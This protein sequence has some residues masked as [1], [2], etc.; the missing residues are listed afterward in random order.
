MFYEF[1]HPMTADYFK[2]ESG[3]DFSY[4]AHLHHCFEIIA[5]TEGEMNVK[6]DSTEYILHKGEALFVFPNQIHSLHTQLHSSHVLCLFSS[7]LVS[8]YS[9]LVTAK[10]PENNLFMPDYFYI[11]QLK[12]ITKESDII[13]IKG[14]LYSLSGV[15]HK[16]ASY[17][18]ADASSNELLYGIFKFIEEHFSGDCSLLELSKHTG[19][20]YTYLSRYFKKILGISYNDYVNQFRISHACYLLTNNDMTILEISDN[21]GFN[22]VRSLNRN[23]KEQLGITPAEYRSKNQLFREEIDKRK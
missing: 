5:I 21:C 14:L 19:Y 20:E 11:D 13:E 15:F 23:F 8:V 18:D 2:G 4:P 17:K 16:I 6:V 3:S 9:R 12:G 7:N 1:K 22:S 10:V